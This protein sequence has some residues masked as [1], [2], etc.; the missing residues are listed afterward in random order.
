MNPLYGPAGVG[1][2]PF[3]RN[4][5]RLPG[6]ALRPEGESEKAPCPAVGN[7]SGPKQGS[8]DHTALGFQTIHLLLR[9]GELLRGAGFPVLAVPRRV[10]SCGVLLLV[11]SARLADAL[12][13]LT[14]TGLEPIEV[15]HYPPVGTE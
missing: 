9:A 14:A 1:P 15:L 13:L 5:D 6:S 8:G 7:P 10:Q 4:P 11:E 12:S 2:F 3:R